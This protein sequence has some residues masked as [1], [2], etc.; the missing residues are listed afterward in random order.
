[1]SPD[2]TRVESSQDPPVWM[3]LRE[4]AF[5]AGWLAAV[6]AIGAI[7]M[8]DVAVAWVVRELSGADPLAIALVQTATSLP[9]MLLVLPA[10]TL[11]DLLDRRRVLA[12]A[13]GWLAACGVLLAW[14][15]RE[16]S[17]V[18][19]VGMLAL[20]ALAGVG[21]ALA[22]PTFSAA[23]AEL[24]RRGE[25]RQAVALYSVANNVARIAG[26]GLA[27][28][29]LYAAG[30]SATFALT[31]AANL[32]ALALVWSVPPARLARSVE[33]RG[34]F[35]AALAEG[36]AYSV[37]DAVYRR[38]VLR[39]ATFFLCA[40]IV[41]A[42][43]PLLVDDARWLGISWGCYGAGAIVGA[44]LFPRIAGRT[45]T[46]RQLSVG[47]ALH[48]SML[49]SLPVVEGDAARAGVLLVLGSAWFSVISGGQLQ[50]QRRLPDALRARGMAVFTLVMMAGF[51]VG[52]VLWGTLA[53]E[54]GVALA[55]W[56]AAATSCAALLVTA[57]L[58][59]DSP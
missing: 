18:G 21:K 15:S 24:A 59:V 30:A 22:L 20:T 36:V 10:G 57:R 32:L 54:A 56:A 51:A 39:L 47:I 14:A 42:M 58:S 55:I 38:V 12:I 53:R 4:A 27:G 49:A 41:H 33:L 29:L 34:R 25:L 28:V 43:L 45:S 31:A 26:P 48:A 19:V 3:P 11:G 35:G 13:V 9:V 37:G 8:Q 5:R 6:L 50:L 1:M 16:D 44:L 46:S 40:T 23:G 2:G 52:A 7:W 17:G